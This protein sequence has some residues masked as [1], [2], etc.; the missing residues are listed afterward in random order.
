MGKGRDPLEALKEATAARAAFLEKH[1]EFLEEIAFQAATPP[2]TVIPAEAPG[3]GP[4]EAE[5]K[6]KPV[7]EGAAAREFRDRKMLPDY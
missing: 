6:W 5:P 3:Q 1:P 7:L 2:P 4:T